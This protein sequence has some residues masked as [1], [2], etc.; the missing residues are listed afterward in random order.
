MKDDYKGWAEV[1]AK[2]TNEAKGMQNLVEE[3]AADVIEKDSCLDHLQKKNGELSTLLK[4][5]KEDI[6]MEFKAFK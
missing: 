6:V 3:L 4:K 5:A 2:A 1:A